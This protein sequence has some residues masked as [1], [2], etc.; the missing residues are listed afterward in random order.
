MPGPAQEPRQSLR[1]Q[2][3]ALGSLQCPEGLQTP[4]QVH[5]PPAQENFNF[6]A[7]KLL[8][9]AGNSTL[10]KGTRAEGG[11]LHSQRKLGLSWK[12][13]E[14]FLLVFVHPHPEGQREILPQNSIAI[15]S[16]SRI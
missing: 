10:F 11:Q 4:S 9:A 15:R 2:S 8:A 1:T 13:R 7:P 12:T 6:L 5:L 16:F 3:P 14:T